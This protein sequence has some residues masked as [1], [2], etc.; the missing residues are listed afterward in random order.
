LRIF[1]YILSIG[2]FLAFGSQIQAQFTKNLEISSYYDDNLFRAPT[3]SSDLLTSFEL[4][5]NYRPEDSNLNMYY[6]GSFLLYRDT[7]DRNFSLHGFG[8][9]FNHSFGDDDRHTLY[10]GSDGNFRLNNEEYNYYDY[11]QIYLYSNIRLDLDIF[12]IKAGYNFRYRNYSNLSDLSNSRHYVFLQANKSFASRTTVIFEADFGYKSFAGENT[13]TI[14]SEGGGHGRDNMVD[15]SRTTTTEE[16]P[17]LKQAIVLIRLAQSLHENLGIFIQHR[18]QI[19]LSDQINYINA[20]GY[21]QDEE[22]FDDP[23]SYESSGAS[24]G[25]TWILPWSMKIQ[26]GGSLFSKNYIA[27]QAYISEDD[28][29]SLGGARIDDQ[30]SIYFNFY[31]SFYID[32]N[33]LRLLKFN[34]YYSYIDNNSNSYWYKYKNA[35]FGGG[36]Q[37][38]F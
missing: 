22:L 29:V 2:F 8:L 30:K 23:F 12:F 36:I 20:D 33:W 21:Y 37:W 32:K 38:S 14:S 17:S 18:R 34:I 19:S 25:V 35:I 1:K 31:K 24:S 4:R 9:F 16:I 7:Y 3:P 10:L 27:E 13:F 26:I 5:L 11:T 15:Q 28:S 6:N